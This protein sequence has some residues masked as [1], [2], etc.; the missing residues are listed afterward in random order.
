MSGW[1]YLIKN[2]DLYKIGI[3]KNFPKR[4][5][6]LKPEKVIVK[7]YS[8]NFK[9][10]EKEFHKR[11]KQVRIPQTEYFR[12]NDKQVNDF[13]QS[14]RSSNH[15]YKLLIDLFT[16][17]FIILCLFFSVFLFFFSLIFNDIQSVVIESVWW[18]RIISLFLSAFALIKGSDCYT[19]LLN[20]I[21]IRISRFI[22]YIIFVAIWQLTFIYLTDKIII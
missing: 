18:M 10:L 6:Q 3:T 20:E 11:Y 2:R 14:I 21:K 5:R 4:M 9:Q 8:R 16:E 1:L 12:L 22:I 7:S 13:I 19:D 15:S 17:I